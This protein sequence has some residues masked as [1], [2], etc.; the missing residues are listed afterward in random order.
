MTGYKRRTIVVHPKVQVRL[1]LHEWLHF[2]VIILSLAAALFLPLVLRLNSTQTGWMEQ[3]NLGRTIL[4]LHAHLW[5]VL[6]LVFILL[7]LHSLI[8]SNRIVGPLPRFHSAIQAFVRGEGWRSPRA[9]KGDFLFEDL[10]LLSDSLALLQQNLHRVRKEHQD[11]Q[12]LVERVV[13]DLESARLPDRR[14]VDFLRLRRQ[15]ARM[16][17][18]LRD[19]DRGSDSEGLHRQNAD[20]G[21]EA[22]TTI[23]NLSSAGKGPL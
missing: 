5:P 15:C 2:V 13:P 21:V 6:L 3:M 7:S 18:A 19:L 11:L 1:L 16:E 12:Q 9:R 17:N 8:I 14:K 23:S 10:K 22:H 20:E 4:F